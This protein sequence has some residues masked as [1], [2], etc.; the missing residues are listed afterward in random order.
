MSTNRSMRLPGPSRTRPSRASDGSAGWPSIAITQGAW[1]SSR[2]ANTRAALALISRRR[3]RSPLL[4]AKS[5][6]SDPLTSA[7]ARASAASPAVPMVGLAAASV[8]GMLG[9]VDLDAGRLHELGIGF[10]LLAHQRLELCRR[11]RHGIGAEAEKL[12]A[13][14]GILQR[15]GDLG[16]KL[17]AD[18]RW[19]LRRR[20]HAGPEI[21][22]RV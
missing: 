5:G 21:V 16:M 7:T 15:L 14:R 12:L 2:S 11:E 13:G 22:F 18:I 6:R 19:R 3:T 9:L 1:P 17:G 8:A 4:T 10:D 20:E